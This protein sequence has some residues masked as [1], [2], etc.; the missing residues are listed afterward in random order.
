MPRPSVAIAALLLAFAAAPAPAGG[1]DPAAVQQMKEWLA[2]CDE[3][4]AAADDAAKLAVEAKAAKLAA[5]PAEA[6]KPISDHLFE[7]AGKTGPKLRSSGGY[8]YD[9]KTK[10][11]RYM[12]ATSGRRHG[13]LL[14]AKHGG[15]D[16]AGDA[17][18]AFGTFGGAVSRG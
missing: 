3:W 6:V 13:G 11:G 4:A 15:G 2:V 7:L 8:F 16:N 5:L 9:E 12:V 10:K 18:S 1:P 17:G 14:I